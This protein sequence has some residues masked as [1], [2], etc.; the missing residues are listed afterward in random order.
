MG[1]GTRHLV[2]AG[3]EGAHPLS[4]LLHGLA[5]GMPD[6]RL[7]DRIEDAGLDQA[8]GLLVIGGHV[9]SALETLGGR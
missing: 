5:P 8:T 2:E 1:V 7:G 6:G 3:P 9:E 4:V